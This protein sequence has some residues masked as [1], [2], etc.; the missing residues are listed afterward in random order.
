VRRLGL[1]LLAV[2][3]VLV[4]DGRA[5]PLSF[6]GAGSTSNLTMAS[7]V[8][9]VVPI[10]RIVFYDEKGVR[11]LVEVNLKTG[12]VTFGPGLDQDAASR[13]AWRSF[14]RWVPGALREMGVERCAR[15]LLGE[16]P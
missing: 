3:V 2:G 6:S 16:E 9:T 1:A 13:E 7:P 4:S 12:G 8:M 5:Q 14:A 10:D 15:V 11:M